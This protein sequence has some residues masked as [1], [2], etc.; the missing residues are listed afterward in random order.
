[1]LTEGKIMCESIADGGRRCEHQTEASRA[2]YRRQRQRPAT[3]SEARARAEEFA[4][5]GCYANAGIVNPLEG[6]TD[7]EIEALRSDVNAIL[8]DRPELNPFSIRLR[9]SKK[10]VQAQREREEAEAQREIEESESIAT[11]RLRKRTPKVV[12]PLSPD[13]DE[14]EEDYVP[15]TQSEFLEELKRM[16]ASKHA[17]ILRSHSSIESTKLSALKEIEK[18][19]AKIRT[20]N[21]GL[22]ALLE[23]SK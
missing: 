8:A 6:K 3:T 2:R 23:A 12:A 15:E 18:W 21:D 19:N 11:A 16:K 10:E 4:S 20:T 7:E 13:D 17:A 1:M 5:Q 9:R 22:F 14:D